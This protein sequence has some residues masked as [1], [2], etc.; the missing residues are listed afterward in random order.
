[1][2][3]PGRLGRAAW[4]TAAR[5]GLDG[6]RWRRRAGRAGWPRIPHGRS[7]LTARS[8]SRHAQV[9]EAPGSAS[10]ASDKR[11]S[12]FIAARERGTRRIRAVHNRE[13]CGRP[14]AR[15]RATS[16][17]GFGNLFRSSLGAWGSGILGR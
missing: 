1:M 5:G 14:P 17:H 4:R 3:W 16:P 2:L 7:R 12:T 6:W 11:R 13:I 9:C 8:C 15:Q 10:N